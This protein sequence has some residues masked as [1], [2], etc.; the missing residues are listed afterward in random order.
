[1][2]SPLN[3][4]IW[5]YELKSGVC[6]RRPSLGEHTLG[7][8]IEQ[9]TTTSVQDDQSSLVAQI[10]GHGWRQGSILPP[11]LFAR[12]SV[13]GTWTPDPE[14]DIGVVLTGD[15]NLL[16]QRLD[17]EEVVDVVFG[18]RVDA[19]NGNYTNL[20]SP[21]ILHLN[22]EGPSGLVPV[23]FS[24]WRRATLARVELAQAPPA[25]SWKV[26]AAAQRTIAE[27]W[28][29][30]RYLRSS[31]P[32][33]FNSR[34]GEKKKRR[35]LESLLKTSKDHILAVYVVVLPDRELPSDEK[36]GVVLRAIVTK[37]A[38]EDLTVRSE[39][40]TQ[41]YDAFLDELKATPGIEV[42]D[43][44]LLS[45]EDFTMSDFRRMNRLEFDYLSY[46]GDDS[47]AGPLP[48]RA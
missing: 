24:A 48:P 16:H 1:V 40:E 12:L 35:K 39:V 32:D 26:N 25:D 20:K 37:E 36:Y 2:S 6:E 41:F 31:F 14:S 45:E 5:L 21:R 13:G 15:C 17:Q 3:Q 33:A 11:S 23:D 4:A 8:R 19:L 43:H 38:Y 34:I 7:S 46:S 9:S 42:L 18:R 27:W 30:G 22:L 44:N 10:A 29:S 47:D 28:A